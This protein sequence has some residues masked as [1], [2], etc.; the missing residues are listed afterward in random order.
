MK[1]NAIYLKKLTGGRIVMLG[2]LG[3]VSVDQC[4]QR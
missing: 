4:R 3:K 2:P 1:S